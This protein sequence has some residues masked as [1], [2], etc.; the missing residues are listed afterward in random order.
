M[1]TTMIIAD[2]A[3][4]PPKLEGIVLL[5]SVIACAVLVITAFI[6]GVHQSQGTQSFPIIGQIDPC[7]PFQLGSQLSPSIEME[8]EERCAQ[9]ENSVPAQ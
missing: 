1:K 8:L 3:R 4:P 5:T 9:Q 6:S 2:T 7:Q